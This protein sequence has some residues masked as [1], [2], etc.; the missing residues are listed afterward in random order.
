[1]AHMASLGKVVAASGIC[2]R[3]PDRVFR[4]SVDASGREL[5]IRVSGGGDP[6]GRPRA[7]APRLRGEPRPTP[8]GDTAPEREA[9][10]HPLFPPLMRPPVRLARPRPP[11]C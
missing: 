11:A 10:R 5:S 7:G 1:M 6:E 9:G 8:R 3:W 2:D 4:F